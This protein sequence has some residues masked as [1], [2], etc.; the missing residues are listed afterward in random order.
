MDNSS[1]VPLFSQY[2]PKLVQIDK[3]RK[4]PDNSS[5]SQ[6]PKP[7]RPHLIISPSLEKKHTGSIEQPTRRRKP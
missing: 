4:D 5:R 7:R 2:S 1:L 3:S 6:V